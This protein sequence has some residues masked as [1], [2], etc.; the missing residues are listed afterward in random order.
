MRYECDMI[1]DLLP[2]YIDG[3]CSGSSKQVV[4]EHLSECPKCAK[5]LE[6]M[7]D[8]LIDDEII[9]EKDQVIEKQAKFFKRKSA[10]AGTIVGSI[11]AIPILICLIVDIAAGSGLSWF[12]IVLSAML[13]PTSLFVV[14]LMSSK[15]KMFNTMV[16]FTASVILLLGICCIFDGGN[17][18]PVAASAV[19]FGL[20]VCFSP[21]IVCRRPVDKFLKNFKGITAMAACTI[22][23]IIMMVCIGIVTDA[24]NYFA[25]AFGISAPCLV[26]IW[27]LFLII[28]YLHVNGFLKAAI[29]IGIISL[30]SAFANSFIASIIIRTQT[31]NNVVVYSDSSIFTLVVGLSIAAV[32]LVIG[33]LVKL[34]GGKKNEEV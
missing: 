10:L 26:I 25:Y 1:A 13:I 24:P 17:W 9:K 34:F 6:K 33:I 8:S 11:F 31:T 15:N 2:L 32:F 12:F 27:I 30:F 5:M 23:Y 19:L 3:A 29:S 18:F 28:R 7:K 22:T 4:E 14:P 20:T 16:S 21:F